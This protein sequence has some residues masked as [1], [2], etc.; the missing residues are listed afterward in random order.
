MK[1]TAR[2]HGNEHYFQLNLQRDESLPALTELRGILLES[3]VSPFEVNHSGLI[4]ALL[5]Y[6]ADEGTV[7]SGATNI[8]HEHGQRLRCF[9]NVFAG[10]P[11]G[12]LF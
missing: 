1:L 9:L 7:S 4:K 11:V 3:D 6:L 2:V 5:Q 12:Y 8:R 10:C